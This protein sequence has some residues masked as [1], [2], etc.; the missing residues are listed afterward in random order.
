MM[1]DKPVGNEAMGVENRPDGNEK[2]LDQVRAGMEVYDTQ[3]ERIGA[4]VKAYPG[5][6]TTRTGRHGEE[7]SGVDEPDMAREGLWESIEEALDPADELAEDL[8]ARLWR[9]GFIRIDGPGLMAEDRYILPEQVAS[10][11]D[12]GVRLNISLDEL[13]RR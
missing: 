10:I 5:R 12:R 9:D 4:V 2:S 6:G 11:S 3:G 7:A 1:T 13:V 8:R